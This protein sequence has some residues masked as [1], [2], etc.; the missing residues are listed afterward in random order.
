MKIYFNTKVFEESIKDYN[1]EITVIP[2]EAFLLVL[3]AKKVNFKDFDNLKAVYRF[4]VGSDNIDFDFLK[5]KLIPIYFPSEKAK[6]I[7][8]DSVANFTVYGIFTLLFRHAFGDIDTWKKNQRDYI[9]KKRALVIGVGNIG[10]RVAAKLKQFVEVDTYDVLYNKISELKS[11]LKE[12]DIITIHIP[13]TEETKNFF[14]AEKLSWVKDDAI[15]VN[16]A[17]G[18]LFEEDALYEKLRSTNC[19][20]FFDVFWN[21]PYT[22]KLK[23]LGNDKFFMTPHTASNSKEFIQ[24]AFNDIRNIIKDLKNE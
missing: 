23:E 16:T 10:Q 12:A 14:N 6:S 3:G 13:L 24:A 11:F 5:K 18:M 20:A 15:I 22:G 8:Y 1:L 9:G 19:R 2:R 4:G 17:R 21:E 7:L